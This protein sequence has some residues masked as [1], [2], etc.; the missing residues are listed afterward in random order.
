MNYEVKSNQ[1]PDESAFV[2]GGHGTGF[3]LR[4]P[5]LMAMTP[6]F[7][8]TRN[9]IMRFFP[10][11]SAQQEQALKSIEHSFTLLDLYGEHI[12]HINEKENL[13]TEL[14]KR[15]VYVVDTNSASQ[16]LF[17]EHPH[18]A[19]VIGS[20][21]AREL[22]GSEKFIFDESYY[23]QGNLFEV[24]VIPSWGRV[25]IDRLDEPY[26]HA[27][28]PQKFKE[29]LDKTSTL[30]SQ[31]VRQHAINNY[32]GKDEILTFLSVECLSLQN[33]SK[34]LQTQKI[35]D[36]PSPYEMRNVTA[37]L[38]SDAKTRVPAAKYKLYKSIVA[39]RRVYIALL[40]KDK[41]EREK[42][43]DQNYH[44][45]L[46]DMQVVTAAIFLGAKI[47][48]EDKRLRTMATEHAGIECRSIGDISR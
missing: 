33:T 26:K 45:I 29:G 2:A 24:G 10:A 30:F 34:F 25:I 27:F 14:Q 42:F 40:L 39:A 48:T 13:L 1:S 47:V 7:L 22:T 38:I 31:Q 5:S 8:W 28:D 6:I 23:K 43:D 12:P 41:T 9:E 20:T 46:G 3:V 17:A 18:K 32:F 36:L 15:D 21:L 37:K 44:N 16:K 4:D 11:G 19:F 35:C